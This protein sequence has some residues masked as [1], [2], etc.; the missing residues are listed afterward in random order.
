MVIPAV[1][2]SGGRLVRLVRGRGRGTVYGDPLEWLERLASA[3][4]KAVHIVDLDAARGTGSNRPLIR[5]LAERASQAGMLAQVGGGIRSIP[6]ALEAASWGRV[7]VVLGTLVYEE[8]RAAALLVERLGAE[9]VAAALDVYGG[10]AYL[11][12]W[13]RAGPPLAEAA[14]VLAGAGFRYILYT[15]VERD[16]TLSGPQ[17]PPRALAEAFRVIVAGGVSSMDDLL[18]LRGAGA[19]GA[20]VGRA[21]L[22]GRIG[23]EDLS[24]MRWEI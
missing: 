23:L 3:G 6:E 7:R 14:R 21:L 24:S 22:E 19:Y 17:P 12:G 5:M 18:S 16:G 10:R 2:V 11:R 4:A 20:V 13:R 9:R 8:P 1:D 15:S